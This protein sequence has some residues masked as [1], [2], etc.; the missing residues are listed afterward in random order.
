MSTVDLPLFDADNH[1]YEPRDSFTR[2][3]EPAYADR[4]VRVENVDGRETIMVAGKPCRYIENEVFDKAGRPGSLKELLKS[5][6][7]S[8]VDE[9][10]YQWEPMRAEYVDRDAR[11]AAMDAQG[12]EACFLFPCMASAVEHFFDDLDAMYAN[13]HSFNRWYD[14]TWGFNFQDRIYAPP[15]LSLQ[16]LDAAVKELDWVL[17]RGARIVTL[18]PGPAAGRSP[19]DPYFDPF[20]ARV[21]EARVTVA[22][23]ITEAGYSRMVAPHWGQAPNPTAYHMSAWQWLHC[24]GDRPIMETISALIYDNLFGRFP[25]VRVT[26]I[27]HG[28]SW[29][30]YLLAQMDK[31]RFMGRNGPWVGGQLMER[32]SEIFRRHVSFTPYPEEDVLALVELVGAQAVLMGSD[33]PHPE[34]LAEPRDFAKLIP[35]LSAEET[36]MILHD[37]AAALVR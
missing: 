19:S 1:C 18:C 2:Y 15:Q 37:N 8:R 4:T 26:S 9:S 12:V 27:E 31:M 32:P 5:M 16:D 23:H 34:G 17:D 35:G 33:W 6:S 20:W 28:A 14:E 3:I 29:V 24:H 36:Q 13:L 21:N 10:G 30:P 11:L 7:S 25:D 22:F